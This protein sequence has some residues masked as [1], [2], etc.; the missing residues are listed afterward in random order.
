MQ[1]LLLVTAEAYPE[2][3]VCHIFQISEIFSESFF[4]ECV[5]LC[6]SL[7]VVSTKGSYGAKGSLYLSIRKEIEKER[8]QSGNCS[9]RTGEDSQVL[10]LVL[11]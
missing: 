7:F 1:T 5:C 4:L 3:K 11:A 9:T 8:S 10:M 2:Q 6:I